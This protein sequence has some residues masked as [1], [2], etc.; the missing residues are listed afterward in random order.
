MSSVILRT[1]AL[2]I[3]HRFSYTRYFT[4]KETVKNKLGIEKSI[5]KR[6][7]QKIPACE[8]VIFKCPFP[9]CGKKNEHSVISAKGAIGDVLSFI[10]RKCGREI[11]VTKPTPKG[12]AIIV[13]GIET[14]KPF[15]LVD[16]R[17]MPLSR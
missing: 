17:G 6:M 2:A 16:A 10:C 1:Q 15:G 7:E 9:A 13:P 3:G 14:T 8:T 5:K 4:V 11:E 12:P